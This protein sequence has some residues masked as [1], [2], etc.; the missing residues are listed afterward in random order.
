MSPARA[1]LRDVPPEGALTISD[2]VA[3]IIMRNYLL[4]ES[5]RMRI[6]NFHALAEKI[7]SEVEE[8]TG[9]KAKP[10]TVVVAKKR[11]S[12]KL[13]TKTA[14]A[15]DLLKEAKLSLLGN[16]TDITILGKPG[17][18]MKIM[19][20]VLKLS[21]QFSAK[22]SLFQLPHSVKVLADEDDAA[23]LKNELAG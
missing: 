13:G 19:E 14:E 8:L 15:V 21:H 22:L 5:L 10:A 17:S 3:R 16:V 7:L 9:T 20:D 12:D 4:H 23:P 6:V 2:A 11:F 1:R 18:T